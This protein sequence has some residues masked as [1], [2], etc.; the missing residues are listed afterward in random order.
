M[1]VKRKVFD[2]HCHIGEMTGYKF[3]GLPEPVKPSV[4]DFRDVDAQLQHMDKFGVERALVMSNYGIP[5]PKQPF[6]LNPVVM[7]SIDKGKDRIVGAIW[8]SGAPRDKDLTAEA[9]K[10]AGTS[11]VKVLKTTCLLGGTYNPDEW[12][13]EAK[14]LWN[15]VVEVAEKHKYIF[16]L[17]TSPGGGSDVSNAIKFVRFYGKRVKIHI[18]HMGGGVSGHIKFVP[19]FFNLIEEGYDVYTDSTWAVGFGPR[20]LFNE[21]EKRGIGHERFLFGSDEPWSDFWSEYYKIEGADISEEFKKK[22]FWENAD[23]LYGG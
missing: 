16:H 14:A 7:D 5:D 21:M 22:I 15:S 1:K 2:A 19:E 17:H 8:F 3:Y 12:D 20:F 23:R 10:L 13:D 18:V 6:G 11:R 9:L 4:Y